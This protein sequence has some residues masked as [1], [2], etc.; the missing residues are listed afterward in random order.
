MIEEAI[1]CRPTV[2]G[3]VT[4]LSLLLLPLTLLYGII[5]FQTRALC[6]LRRLY[7]VDLQLVMSR[8]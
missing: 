6:C 4:G 3:D 2:I 7:V 5:N 8:N 1:C